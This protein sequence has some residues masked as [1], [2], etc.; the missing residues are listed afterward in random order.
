MIKKIHSYCKTMWALIFRELVVFKSDFWGTVLDGVIATSVQMI[1][2]IYILPYFGLQANFGAFMLGGFVASSIFWRL[3]SFSAPLI[4]DIT[5]ERKITYELMLPIPTG[6]VFLRMMISF[7]LQAVSTSCVIIPL[8]KLFLGNQF[9]LTNISIFKTIVMFIAGSFFVS[10]FGIFIVS[11]IHHMGQ[12]SSV[13]TRFLFPLWMLGGFN[14][15]WQSMNT[16]IPIIS[17]ITL[18]NPMI[19]FHE[20][21]RGAI[22]GESGFISVIICVP[23]L[24]GFSI[25]FSLVGIGKIKKKLDCM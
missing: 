3:Y 11:I 2:T 21:F 19:Y 1:V 18:L 15:S 17:Y 13:W 6:L 5:G 20:G 10:S 24:I 22:L 7:M 25:L 4:A 8:G 9:D 16:M 12:I 14:F 23:I